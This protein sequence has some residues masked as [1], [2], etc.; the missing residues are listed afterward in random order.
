MMQDLM[1]FCSS[2]IYAVEKN[3]EGLILNKHYLYY[4]V[5]ISLFNGI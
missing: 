4:R 1:G 5:F 3:E 2:R